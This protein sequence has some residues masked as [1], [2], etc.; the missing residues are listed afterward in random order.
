ML[1]SHSIQ[2]LLPVIIANQRFPH[3]MDEALATL[4]PSS[5]SRV[6]DMSHQNWLDPMLPPMCTDGKFITIIKGGPIDNRV[7]VR[8]PPGLSVELG[9]RDGHSSP[10]G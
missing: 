2:D 4:I 9:R 10:H 7:V 3:R 8:K 6:R 1:L 5:L